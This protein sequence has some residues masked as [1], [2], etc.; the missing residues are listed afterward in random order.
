MGKKRRGKSGTSAAARK[1]RRELATDNVGAGQ[2]TVT[3]PDIIARVRA[4][5]LF[6]RAQVLHA[7]DIARTCET[8]KICLPLPKDYGT[9][10]DLVIKFDPPDQLSRYPSAVYSVTLAGL[11]VGEKEFKE[12]VD[13]MAPR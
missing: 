13:E 5:P 8:H 10:A 12:L 2:S 1:R 9:V 11:L 7:F 6:D 3:L 4:H